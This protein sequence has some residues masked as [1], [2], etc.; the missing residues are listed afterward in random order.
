MPHPAGFVQIW[1]AAVLLLVAVATAA[2]AEVV[3]ENLTFFDGDG[4]SYV[5][6]STLRSHYNSYELYQPG[7]EDAALDGYYYI[8]PNEYDWR[9]SDV[10]PNVLRFP[11]GD[12]ALLWGGELGERVQ[13]GDNGV[14]TYSSWDG[15]KRE[16]GHFGIW[17]AGGP[18]DQLA[19]AWV[20]PRDFEIL[21]YESNRAGDWVTRQNTLSYFGRRVNDVTFTIRFRRKAQG[22]YE[23]LKS[24]LT[25]QQLVEVA[26]GAEGVRVTMQEAVLFPS[27]SAA[28]TSQ[29]RSLLGGMVESLER[30]G[31]VSVI[32]EG[33]TDNVPIQG[34]LADR[35][36]TN[37]EL[38]AARSLAVLHRLAD[39]GIP[40]RSLQARAFGPYRPRDSNDTPE[41]RARNRR[42]EL[43]INPRN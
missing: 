34:E 16:D 7:G 14:Y 20:F 13:A 41:G 40:E 22:I 26:Q 18:F 33:H 37:W 43:V 32:I 4:K 3:R 23:A 17:N 10:E 9:T 36:P 28:L 8:Y 5:Q 35:Y 42:V 38:S 29:G 30:Q 1:L 39:L 6:Y 24:D 25:S 2:S 12:Y 11:Q 27:G 31:K 19:M 15:R 21:S